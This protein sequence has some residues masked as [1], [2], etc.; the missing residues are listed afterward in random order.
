V[1]NK[2]KNRFLDVWST[3]PWLTSHGSGGH[4]GAMHEQ[5]KQGAKPPGAALEDVN[6]ARKPAE[7]EPA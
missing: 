7:D 3:V 4:P 5:E 2:I 1:R 6:V